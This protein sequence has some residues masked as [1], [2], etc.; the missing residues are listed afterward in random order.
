MNRLDLARPL[1]TTQ[2]ERE[3][4]ALRLA[5]AMCVGLLRAETFTS[6]HAPIGQDIFDRLEWARR[7]LAPLA[8]RSPVVRQLVLLLGDEQGWRT[9]NR[10][11]WARREL[12][13]LARA[14][15]ALARRMA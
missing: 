7:R 5:L 1:L 14:A 6:E 13:R 12:H 2:S 11:R 8:A 9:W 15:F 4:A 3:R 10:E